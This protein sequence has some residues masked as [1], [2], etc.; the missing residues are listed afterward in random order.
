M[1]IDANTNAPNQ[2]SNPAPPPGF[3][4]AAHDYTAEELLL[5]Y[6]AERIESL[7][8]RMVNRGLRRIGLLGSREHCAWLCAKIDAMRILPIVAFIDRPDETRPKGDIGVPLRTID[9][10]RLAEEIDVVLVAD[11]RAENALRDLAEI[12]LPP[13]VMIFTIYNRLAIGDEPLPITAT[14]IAEAK[15]SSRASTPTPNAAPPSP[16]QRLDRIT[17]GAVTP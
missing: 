2:P 1:T 14:T 13:K 12:N 8:D 5:V 3:Q 9:D 10:P 7:C 15:P 17:A 4:H 16:E 6:I 11:D